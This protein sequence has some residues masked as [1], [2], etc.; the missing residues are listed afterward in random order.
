MAEMDIR[1]KR[2]LTF[3]V[4]VSL[5][6]MFAV[7]SLWFDVRP[8]Q[9]TGI[10]Q[11][12]V[13]YL[14]ASTVYITTDIQT[15][16]NSRYKADT[17]EFIYCLHGSQYKDGYLI[18][19]IDETKVLNSSEGSIT[20]A[21][22]KRSSDY[23]GTLHSHPA[24]GNYRFIPSCHLSSQDIY[25]FGAEKQPLTAVICG[26]DQFGFYSTQDFENSYKVVTVTLAN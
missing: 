16:L 7:F 17:Q 14:N 11:S 22:C 20:Y 2:L 21:Q 10:F 3:L 1:S 4:V 12:K 26:I 9:Y 18:K 5:V 13:Q 24:T 23:L 6:S 19:S 15:V 8:Q 25:T